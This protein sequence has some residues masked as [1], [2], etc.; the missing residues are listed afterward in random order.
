MNW[1]KG[2]AFSS[3]TA[4]AASFV[5]EN[6]NKNFE[7]KPKT[8]IESSFLVNGKTY[9]KYRE[10]L[11]SKINHNFRNSS[12]AKSF[13]FWFIFTSVFAFY[14]FVFCFWAFFFFLFFLIFSHFLFNFFFIIFLLFWTSLKFIYLTRK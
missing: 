13:C 3:L 9:R 11:I 8:G 10:A 7:K 5:A 6:E 4:A 1:K 14:F 2:F 12:Q